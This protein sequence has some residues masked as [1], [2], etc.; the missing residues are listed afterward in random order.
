MDK[1]IALE[2]AGRFA[3]ALRL[4][5]DFIKI[6]MFGSYAKGNQQTESDIDLAIVFKDFPDRF[7]M[8]LDLMRIRRSI[9]SRIEPHPFRSGDFNESNPLVHEILKF[10]VEI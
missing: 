4:K 2:K 10:G 3:A 7:D 5:Y 8:Q 1:E 6:I 9:D